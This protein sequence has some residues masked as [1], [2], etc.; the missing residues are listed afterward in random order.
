[1]E[2]FLVIVGNI[3]EGHEFFGPFDDGDDACNWAEDNVKLEWLIAH[4]ETPTIASE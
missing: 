4:L 1:V 3:F 2:K